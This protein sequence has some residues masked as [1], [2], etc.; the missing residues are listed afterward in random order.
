MMDELA[1]Q[2]QPV[3]I[4]EWVIEGSCKGLKCLK[5]R[6]EESDKDEYVWNHGKTSGRTW[7][8][9]SSYDEG[10]EETESGFYGTNNDM[11]DDEEE[12]NPKEIERLT[13]I[14]RIE[15][16]QTAQMQARLKSERRQS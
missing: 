7:A 3:T 10:A 6:E 15:Q 14:T 12:E 2:Y 11:Q 8:A 1:G 4:T 13:Y 9:E 5:T 16:E